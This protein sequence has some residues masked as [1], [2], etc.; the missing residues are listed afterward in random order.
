VTQLAGREDTS[1]IDRERSTPT[2]KPTQVHHLLS[3]TRGRPGG[4]D[5]PTG[6]KLPDPPCWS[7]IIRDIGHGGVDVPL[8]INGDAEEKKIHRPPPDGE[9]LACVRLPWLATV[10]AAGSRGRKTPQSFVALDLDLGVNLS[11]V[12]KARGSCTWRR[13]LRWAMGAAAALG[14]DENAALPFLCARAGRLAIRGGAPAVASTTGAPVLRHAARGPRGG[15]AAHRERRLAEAPVLCRDADS[16][17]G[18]EPWAGG[19]ARCWATATA[20]RSPSR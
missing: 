15:G 2:S 20:A 5:C 16:V 14:V 7:T 9:H 1:V 17:R 19:C 3:R 18:P 10:Y 4:Q 13:V 11:D 12:L 6:S 8:G